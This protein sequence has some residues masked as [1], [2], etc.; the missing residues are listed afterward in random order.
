[1]ILLNWYSYSLSPFFNWLAKV[2][3]RSFRLLVKFGWVPNA[4]I[5]STIVLLFFTWM[6]MLRRYAKEGKDKGL[7]D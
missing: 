6:Y 2:F 4:I 1:M 3:E 5:I 7:I